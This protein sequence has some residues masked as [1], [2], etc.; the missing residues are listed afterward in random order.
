VTFDQAIDGGVRREIDA[1]SRERK[2]SWAPE[3]TQDQLTKLVLLH[4]PINQHA[5]TISYSDSD[6]VSVAEMTA[7]SHLRGASKNS[8]HLWTILLESTINGTIRN[9]EMNK[10]GATDNSLA[11]K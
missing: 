8:S 1:A 2:S 4:Y 7:K 10:D 9:M 5:I 11:G 6:H 3:H